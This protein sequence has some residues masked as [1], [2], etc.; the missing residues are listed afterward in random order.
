MAIP[1]S[2]IPE[3]YLEQQQSLPSIPTRLVGSCIP[4]TLA[5][6]SSSSLELTCSIYHT[7]EADKQHRIMP[8]VAALGSQPSWHYLSNTGGG[9]S[10]DTYG[11]AEGI[12]QQHSG[13]T[14]TILSQYKS[15][16]Y[17][18]PS[19]TQRYSSPNAGKNSAELLHKP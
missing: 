19:S 7:R 12:V 18:R 10:S 5:H 11:D 15:D 3:T 6:S 17:L 14:R 9:L 8:L 4:S 2:I 16:F 1:T 13:L